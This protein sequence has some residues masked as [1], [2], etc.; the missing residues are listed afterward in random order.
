M[1]RTVKVLDELL[2]SA[3][4]KEDITVRNPKRLSTFSQCPGI[5]LHRMLV[6]RRLCLTLLLMF[7]GSN[8]SVI[9]FGVRICVKS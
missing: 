8:S 6:G 5:W 7:Q 4:T 3:Q 9:L 1:T 2:N